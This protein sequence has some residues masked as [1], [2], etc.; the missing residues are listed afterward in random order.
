MSDFEYV[1]GNMGHLLTVPI[2]ESYYENHLQIQ[3]HLDASALYKFGEKRHKKLHGVIGIS[4]FNIYNQKNI[5]SREYFIGKTP[6]G[7]DEIKVNDYE[8][9]GFT[10]NAVIRVEW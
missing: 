8:G 9:L 7:T 6:D 2:Y 5:Y 4:I 1:P 10:P 3:H